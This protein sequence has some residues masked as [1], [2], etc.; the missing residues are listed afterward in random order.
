MTMQVNELEIQKG[1]AV[2]ENYLNKVGYVPFVSS[3]SGA[4]RIMYGKLEVITGI[5]LAALEAGRS[6]LQT[7]AHKRQ[8]IWSGAAK[9]L[10]YSLH[11]IANMTRGVA[12]SIPFFNLIGLV[13]DIAGERMRYNLAEPKPPIQSVVHLV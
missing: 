3:I 4:Y 10:R 12:E 1:L 13:W 8:E 7:D 5:A 9:P 11:G 6:A 2:L